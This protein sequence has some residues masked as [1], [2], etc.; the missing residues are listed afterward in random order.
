MCIHKLVKHIHP[1]TR[2]IHIYIEPQYAPRIYIQKKVIYEYY[3]H[4]HI[5]LI[6]IDTYIYIHMHIQ[7]RNIY[8]SISHMQP[9]V[10]Y[11]H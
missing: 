3:V 4:T 10:C 11:H 6:H 9:C 5:Y 7:I 8:V 2:C 1:E